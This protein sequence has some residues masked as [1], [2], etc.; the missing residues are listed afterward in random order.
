L[1]SVTEDSLLWMWNVDTGRQIGNPLRANAYEDDFTFSPNGRMLAVVSSGGRV[2]LVDTQ[3]GGEVDGSAIQDHGR[4]G[5]AVFSP[6]SRT[7]AITGSAGVRLWDVD[8][9]KQIGDPLPVPSEIRVLQFSPDGRTLAI[10]DSEKVVRFWDLNTHEQNGEPLTGFD[11]DLRSIAFSPD[12]RTVATGTF[13][14]WQLRGQPVTVR[15]WDIGTRRQI[16]DPFQDHTS[17]IDSLAFSADGTNLVS[18]S[19]DNTINKWDTTP[20]SDPARTICD[21]VGPPSERQWG[22]YSPDEP[23]PQPC[24]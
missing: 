11:A 1:A 20:Y 22:Q 24:G 5:S 18:A 16:G 23:L 2:R 8:T 21:R 3:T 17:T 10:G 13:L 4:S 14:N 9:K 7:L 19:N 12:G 6:D 15:L